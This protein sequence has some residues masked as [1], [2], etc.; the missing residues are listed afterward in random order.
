MKKSINSITAILI[1]IIV[2]A[3]SSCDKG[4]SVLRSK[5]SLKIRYKNNLIIIKKSGQDNCHED[6]LFLKSG[7]YYNNNFNHRI[8]LTLSTIRDTLIII[9]PSIYN[10]NEY[11]LYVGKVEES[12]FGTLRMLDNSERESIYESSLYL[13]NDKSNDRDNMHLISSYLYDKKYR[14][15]KVFRNKY[16]CY[17]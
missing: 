5:E 17:E 9:P 2:M 3:T 12:P 6:T 11:L 13:I 16:T 4:T 1:A 15:I 14:I 10:S 7:E 8:V